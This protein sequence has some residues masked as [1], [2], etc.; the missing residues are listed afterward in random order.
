MDGIWK[1]LK[2]ESK[3]PDLNLLFINGLV[4]FSDKVLFL[5]KQIESWVIASDVKIVLDSIKNVFR[6]SILKNLSRFDTSFCSHS[7]HS[8]IILIIRLRANK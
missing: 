4:N 1:S 2:L 7:T 6:I 8:I 5:L 3:F